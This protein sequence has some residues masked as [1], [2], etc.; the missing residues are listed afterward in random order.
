MSYKLFRIASTCQCDLSL[1][2]TRK[3]VGVS[4]THVRAAVVDGGEMQALENAEF[5]GFELGWHVNGCCV[6]TC[7]VRL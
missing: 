6:G 1:F 3:Q 4:R 2:I 7:G 5:E